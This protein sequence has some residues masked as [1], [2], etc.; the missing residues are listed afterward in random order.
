MK[1]NVWV[2][3]LF[4][5][6]CGFILVQ[7]QM[8]WMAWWYVCFVAVRG[9]EKLVPAATKRV[10]QESIPVCCKCLEPILRL[11][12]QEALGALK[13]SSWRWWSGLQPSDCVCWWKALP[14][15]AVVCC[16]DL[17]GKAFYRLHVCLFW[18]AASRP[19]NPRWANFLCL[20]CCQQ[21]L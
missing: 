19:E 18:A 12:C 17:E 5:F 9:L 6:F 20:V 11:V 13:A 4:F 2:S 10:L 1:W 8:V 16:V 21:V 15:L 14:A 3:I 7:E